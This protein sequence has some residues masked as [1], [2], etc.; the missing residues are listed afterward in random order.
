MSVSRAQ[1][2][3]TPSIVCIEEA[4]RTFLETEQKSVKFLSIGAKCPP[5]LEP[6]LPSQASHWLP[7]IG[8]TKTDPTD[9]PSVNF[10]IRRVIPIISC[11]R[12]RKH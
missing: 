6:L 4:R 11:H 8:L 2:Y 9:I 3:F 12:H 1:F 10:N 7:K 5:L